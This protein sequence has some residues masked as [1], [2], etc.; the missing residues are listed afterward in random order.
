LM[1][2]EKKNNTILITE[3]LVDIFTIQS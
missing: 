1:I 3:L 2:E